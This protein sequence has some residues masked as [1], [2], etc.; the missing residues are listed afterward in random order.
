MPNYLRRRIPGGTF[1]FTARL[2]DRS[3]DLLVR[4]IERLRH[5][6]RYTRETRPFY[7][8]AIVVLPSAIHTIWTLPDSDTDYSKRWRTLKAQFTKDLPA[9]QK[10][11]PSQIKRGEKGIWQ[12]R[13]WE[14]HIRDA[15]D[16]AAH[17]TFIYTV[18]VQ[19]GF[20]ARPTDWPYSSIH[21][22]QSLG[23]THGYALQTAESAHLY[24]SP[25]GAAQALRA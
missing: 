24:Q 12:S 20:V 25:S 6:V 21:R 18:P 11:S 4:E 7:I 5:A 1:F 13:F 2:K 16:L 19:E 9:P 10:R 3:S 8:D 22:D 23:L 17:R 14:H 15:R